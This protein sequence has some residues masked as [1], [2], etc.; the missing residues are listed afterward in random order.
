MA[1]KKDKIVTPKLK[2]MVTIQCMY[3][4]SDLEEIGEIQSNLD[5]AL[6]GLR[7]YG[8]AEA[9]TSFGLV[10]SGKKRP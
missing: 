6:E 4:L 3:E 10:K 2:I 1:T 5:A 8:S 7:C 9:T